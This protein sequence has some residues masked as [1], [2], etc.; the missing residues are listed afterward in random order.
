MSLVCTLSR[1]HLDFFLLL[2]YFLFVSAVTVFIFLFFLFCRS[3]R[4]ESVFLQKT[5]A[6]T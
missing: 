2:H 3:G 6:V 4:D 5:V 1:M